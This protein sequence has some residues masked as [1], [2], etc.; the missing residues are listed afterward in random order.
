M[1]HKNIDWKTIKQKEYLGWRNLLRDETLKLINSSTP[2]KLQELNLIGCYHRVREDDIFSIMQEDYRKLDKVPE[3]WLHKGNC[4]GIWTA[5]FHPVN[6]VG[7]VGEVKNIMRIYF[8]PGFTL[9]DP[10]NKN[11]QEEW[12]KWSNPNS[13][14]PWSILKNEKG[15]SLERRMQIFRAPSHRKFFE[16]NKY[17]AFVGY[18]DYI[19]IVGIL[20]EAIEKVEFIQYQKNLCFTTH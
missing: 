14:N 20:P 7:F 1:E 16:Q 3:S 13:E 19:C 5:L 8:Q 17:G 2:L 12:K 6:T 11:Q 18:S 15:A 9:F 4:P 10:D